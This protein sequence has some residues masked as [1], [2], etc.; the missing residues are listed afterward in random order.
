[1]VIAGII[2][3]IRGMLKRVIIGMVISFVVVLVLHTLL[4]FINPAGS[5]QG[6]ND[7]LNALLGMTRQ[8]SSPTVL[9]FWFLLTAIIAFFYSQIRS[10]GLRKTGHKVATLPGW[11]LA[12]ARTTGISAVPLAMGGVAIALLV[13]MFFLNTLT[14]IQFL[15][16]MLGLLLSQQESMGVLALRLGYSDLYRFVRKTGPH[17]PQPGF[18]VMGIAGAG[19]GFV[20]VLFVADIFLIFVGVTIIAIAGIF[21][22]LSQ[23]HRTMPV[24]AGVIILFGLLILALVTVPVRAD[25]SRFP[26]T[27][28]Y[29]MHIEYTVTGATIDS[30]HDVQDYHNPS[31]PSQ[32]S[33][34]R[35]MTGTITG[36]TITITGK[37]VM[38]TDQG[39]MMGV[40]N[41]NGGSTQQTL[42]F[43]APESKDFT[44]VIPVST[45]TTSTDF[46]ISMTGYVS[47]PGTSRA[48]RPDV[49][50][51]GVFTK[52]GAAQGSGVTKTPVSQGNQNAVSVPT[53]STSYVNLPVVTSLTGP[54]TITPGSGDPYTLTAAVTGGTPPYSYRWLDGTRIIFEGPQYS[55]VKVT[56]N[57]FYTG[58]SGALIDLQVTDAKQNMASWT[59]TDGIAHWQFSLYYPDT[60]HQI[61]RLPEYP[62][63]QTKI[64][65][66]DNAL[67]GMNGIPGLSTL[68]SVPGVPGLVTAVQTG[69]IAST[70]S[71]GI[72]PATVGAV[73]AVVGGALGAFVLPPGTIPTDSGTENNSSEYPEVDDE[74]SA[75][76]GSDSSDDTGTGSSD[77]STSYSS[78][79]PG[80]AY[81]DGSVQAP[82]SDTPTPVFD[83]TPTPP[84]S[85]PPPDVPVSPPAPPQSPPE[86]PPAPPGPPGDDGPAFTWVDKDGITHGANT[87]QEM[88]TA[89]DSANA[90][91]HAQNAP[92]DAKDAADFKN[93]VDGFKAKMDADKAKLDKDSFNTWYK[94]YL[95]EDQAT[96][97]FEAATELGHASVMNV[98]TTGL[99]I[100]EKTADI[101][102]DIL[103]KLTGPEG[104]YV[105]TAYSALKDVGK[106]ISSSHA[107]GE[108]LSTGVVKGVEEAGFDFAWSQAKDKIISLNTEGKIPYLKA[109]Q[110]PFFQEFKGVDKGGTTLTSFENAITYKAVPPPPPMTITD[111]GKL[112]NNNQIR[113]GT[114]NGTI[115]AIQNKVQNFVIKDPLKKLAGF[116]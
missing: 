60:T 10:N 4:M 40:V 43:R 68:A 48:L 16:I 97:Q 18:P 99:E 69:T 113:Q 24:K 38:T 25:P 23:K 81:G 101:S 50:L 51:S 103:T 9:L 29:G 19:A 7:L 95:K 3:N 77:T 5:S 107:K 52:P 112:I 85:P 93:L 20:I 96:N 71:T 44:F 53:P 55:S 65:D 54:Q 111:L 73:G 75:S 1:M 32:L 109:K 37:E 61:Q 116:K 115:N 94:G 92:Q 64:V 80:P 62:Y 57:D 2:K 26:N 17:I 42:N 98:V 76:D 12:A 14:S 67:A 79:S 89:Q 22:F 34:S 90:A 11:I 100:T 45:G 110:L 39:E 56:Y 91:V 105:K 108:S 70:A 13:R 35:E 15:V 6:T 72:V 102:V 66:H 104:W 30:V 8:Q 33:S 63:K 31:N 28:Y 41:E 82:Y 49:Y 114:F 87:Q 78:G 84:D 27:D 59:G 46:S 47:P 83:H 36:D 106:N 86:P 88:E 58:G 74:T 21:Y